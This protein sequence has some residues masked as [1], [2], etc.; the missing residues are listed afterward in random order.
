MH[1]EGLRA[2]FVALPGRAESGVSLAA[3]ALQLSLL[4]LRVSV[5]SSKTPFFSALNPKP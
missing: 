5:R 2:V 1:Q 4:L 3:L